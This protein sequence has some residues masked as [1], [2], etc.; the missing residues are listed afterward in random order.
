M[1][2]KFLSFILAICLIIPCS[3]MLS[4]CG[5]DDDPPAEPIHHSITIRT[6]NNL[7][8]R[9]E[10]I[11]VFHGDREAMS[12]TNIYN[13][14]VK[15]GEENVFIRLT[16]NIENKFDFE[17]ATLFELVINVIKLKPFNTLKNI[18]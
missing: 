6:L 7:N 18:K 1:K 5:K 9:I 12:E 17:T 13:G 8:D 11:I 2:K 15:E 4:A 16:A 10:S 14:T 3:F